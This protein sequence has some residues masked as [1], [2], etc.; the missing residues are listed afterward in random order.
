MFK[1][2]IG[3]LAYIWDSRPY[4]TFI[5]KL[6][7]WN[8]KCFW[9]NDYWK[10]RLK[11]AR[12]PLQIIAG[13]LNITILEFLCGILITNHFYWT[14][15][16]WNSYMEFWQ[17]ITFDL[18]ITI[19]EFL[20]G[21]LITNHLRISCLLTIP[22]LT[23]NRAP[24]HDTSLWSQH[25]SAEVQRFRLHYFAT[26]SHSLDW[27]SSFYIFL[28]QTD[29]DANFWNIYCL[30]LHILKYLNGFTMVHIFIIRYSIIIRNVHFSH[31]DQSFELDLRKLYIL[32][33][34]LLFKHHF[35]KSHS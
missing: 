34:V 14:S 30:H 17:Q 35:F 12:Q 5:A 28:V 11:I 25:D 8:K 29:A 6:K 33:A 9:S 21:I 7:R 32:K 16:F 20:Y 26:I 1:I 18:N 27:R 3:S 4:S 23:A 19:L 24:L 10:I 15:L 31:F 13:C 22:N 2:Q